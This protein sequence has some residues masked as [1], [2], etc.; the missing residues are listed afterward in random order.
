MKKKAG[1]STLLTKID[2]A[3]RNQRH[4]T[5]KAVSEA[6]R[7]Q[8]REERNKKLMAWV[9]IFSVLFCFFFHCRL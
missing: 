6:E 7:R 3:F 9:G 8:K 1:T 5:Q 2:Q 4:G